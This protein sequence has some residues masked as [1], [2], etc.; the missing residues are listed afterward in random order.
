M[1]IFFSVG[2]PSG[3]LHGANLIRELQRLHPQ[4]R[5]VGYG[6]PRMEQA[7]LDLHFDLTCLAVMFFTEVLSKLPQFFA[8]KK[9]ARKYFDEQRPDAV[10]LIDFPGFNWHI[11]KLAKRRGIPVF[12]FGV[13]QLWAWAP[14]RIRKLRKHVDHVL[15]KLP[16]EPDWFQQRGCQA[17]FVGHPYFDEL[18]QR[19]LDQNWIDQIR[20]KTTGPILT[21]LPGSRDHEVE[22]NAATLVR[23]AELAQKKLPELQVHVAAFNETQSKQFAEFQKASTLKADV[24]VGKTPELIELGKFCVACSGSVSLELMYHKV[25]TVIVYRVS[26]FKMILARMLLRSRYITLVN[27]MDS[28]AGIERRH[29]F[30]QADDQ[31][32]EPIIFPEYLTTDDCSQPVANWIVR[33]Q[34]TP[35][36]YQDRKRRLEEMKQQFALPGAS[37]RAAQLI[38]VALNRTPASNE[39]ETDQDSQF[40]A[41]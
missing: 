8:L 40:D 19:E 31:D 33:W 22:R 15:C 3:D 26:R 10:V 13:P 20:A 11:A 2:E 37:A 1:K 9:R 39:N 35:M 25:P 38:L 28:S 32:A 12:Y 21:L 36:E 16:F 23:A 34:S 14:W 29:G 6:G 17:D 27:L 24:W 7:G 41:A 4:V 30:Y 18:H 5:C